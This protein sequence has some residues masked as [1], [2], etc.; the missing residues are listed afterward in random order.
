[1]LT[2][3]LGWCKLSYLA[4]PIGNPSIYETSAANF[5]QAIHVAIIFVLSI[6][7][8]LLYFLHADNYC[9]NEWDVQI[10]GSRDTS[11]AL[12]RTTR[13]DASSFAFSAVV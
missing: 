6:Q 5:S 12:V 4:L 3:F 9:A 1:V 8:I 2:T 13:V 7:K 11:Q 10:K